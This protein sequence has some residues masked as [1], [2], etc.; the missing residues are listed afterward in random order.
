MI[1][2]PVCFLTGNP[3]R[4]DNERDLSSSLCNLFAWLLVGGRSDGS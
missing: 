2:I 4:R 3:G 1:P